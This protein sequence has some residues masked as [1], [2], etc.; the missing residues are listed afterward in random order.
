MLDR[1]VMR[2]S[3]HKLDYGHKQAAATASVVAGSFEARDRSSDVGTRLVSVGGGAALRRERQP[4]LR[5]GI[6]GL[7]MMTLEKALALAAFRKLLD[8]AELPADFPR[9]S[10]R[11]SA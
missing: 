10:G 6:G 2:E 5:L 11:A 8:G 1:G 9:R 3:V 7:R 4:G